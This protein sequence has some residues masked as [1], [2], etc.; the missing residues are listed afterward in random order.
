MDNIFS[1][2]CKECNGNCCKNYEFFLTKKEL[3]RI[4]FIKEI[5]LKKQNHVFCK[6]TLR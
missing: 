1:K 5:K 4:K 3:T 2:I 6:I